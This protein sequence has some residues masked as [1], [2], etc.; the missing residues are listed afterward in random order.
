MSVGRELDL[1]LFL[2]GLGERHLAFLDRAVQQQ[3]GRELHQPRGQPHAFGG[4]SQRRGALEF[5][6][7]LPAGTVEI[8]RGFFDQRHAVAKQVGEG[9]RT[10]EPLAERHR[11][12][13]AGLGLFGHIATPHLTAERML[14]P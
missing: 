4:I 7:F 13:V 1:A 2:V 14:A 8:G 9:L 12:R 5:L 6:R 10:G 11:L 3:P